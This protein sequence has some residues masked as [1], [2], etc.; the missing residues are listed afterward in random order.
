MVLYRL[1]RCIRGMVC[2]D[3]FVMIVVSAGVAFPESSIVCEEFSQVTSTSSNSNNLRVR[4]GVEQVRVS[5][6]PEY[7]EEDGN[8]DV[9]K[10]WQIATTSPTDLGVKA[11][12][13]ALD[14]A[15]VSIEDVGLL[16]ADTATPRQ[17]C[18]SEAQRIVNGFGIKIPAFD[19]VGALG[20]VPLLLSTCHKRTSAPSD[21]LIVVVSA[22]TPS[23]QVHY[24]AGGEERSLLGDGAVAFV[25]SV[26]N[27]AKGRVLRRASV[28]R[29][30][31]GKTPFSIHRHI[32]LREDGVLSEGELRDCIQTL[33]QEMDQF[34]PALRG[35]AVVVPPQ[36]YAS[37]ATQVL[38]AEGIAQERIVSAVKDG[39]FSFGSSCGI[40]LAKAFDSVD[41]SVPVVALHCGDE[42]VGLIVV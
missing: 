42:H 25:L 7:I 18:P 2:G 28:K 14:R 13:N 36:L 16:L 5:L 31:S 8:Q 17:T 40:A 15:G 33:L 26:H 10:A 34:D 9:L 24:G 12:Q 11:V 19:I 35:A 39:G 20:A 38:V 41:E 23:Q 30:I 27:G 37:E 32:S 22:N 3:F 1:P 21:K 6:P 4:C 29:W